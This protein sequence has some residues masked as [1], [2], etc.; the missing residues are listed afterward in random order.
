MNLRSKLFSKHGKLDLCGALSELFHGWHWQSHKWGHKINPEFVSGSVGEKTAYVMQSGIQFES[1][2]S[3]WPWAHMFCRCGHGWYCLKLICFFFAPYM[4][5]NRSICAL[6]YLTSEVRS[7]KSMLYPL[8]SHHICNC[9]SFQYLLFFIIYPWRW[10]VRGRNV[11]S[12][13]KMQAIN[14]MC[15][16]SCVLHPH[17]SPSIFSFTC[18]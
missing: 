5:I 8:I 4:Y 15:E 17:S 2:C 10:G 13:A 9:S 14:K 12:L 3:Y 6:S 1:G 18:S 16:H 11:K 7:H